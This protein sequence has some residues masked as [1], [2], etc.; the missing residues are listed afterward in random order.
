MAVELA[1]G[2]PMLVEEGTD[3]NK[4]DILVSP[5]AC[6][7]MCDPNDPTQNLSKNAKEWIRHVQQVLKKFVFV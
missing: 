7:M 4:D 2:V 5:H 6:V 3:D 1:G